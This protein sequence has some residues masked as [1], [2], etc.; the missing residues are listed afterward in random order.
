MKLRAD[1]LAGHLEGPLRAIYVVWGDEPLLTMEAA[2][3]IRKAAKSQGIKDRQLFHVEAGFDWNVL[4][5]ENNAM[6][7]FSDRRLLE[8][9]IP[10]GKPSDR[11]EALQEL[12]RSPNPDNVILIQCPKLDSSAQKTRWYK[13]IES[14]G[15]TIP[16]WPIERAQY[17]GW[18]NS[19][20]QLAGI[21]AEREAISYL[22]QQTEGNLL[23]AIQEIEKLKI[24]GIQNLNLNNLED[25]ASNNARYD[26]FYFIDTC[27]IGDGPHALRMLMHLKAIGTS[28]LAI[29]GALTLKLRQLSSLTGLKRNELDEKFKA[30][31]IWPKQ[32]TIL[33]KAL[34]LQDESHLL[35]AM[36]LVEKIDRAT[37]G[38]G[39]D[40]WR[41][42]SELTLLLT[43]TEVATNLA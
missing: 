28:P 41:L 15:V 34:V 18:L 7:L 36:Q 39:E 35:R 20:L 22:A 8:V 31:R 19:R 43:K 10:N 33:R 4:R 5:E 1:Q 38:S 25:N 6:S 40:P 16:V 14:H 3:L 30:L 17:P 9:R 27:L 23:A 21:R 32:Q 29:I 24:L 37:K 42:L 12:A 11:G 2:D 26:A 13:A